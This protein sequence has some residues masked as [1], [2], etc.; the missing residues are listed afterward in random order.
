MNGFLCIFYEF[1]EQLVEDVLLVYIVRAGVHNHR[2][3]SGNG[4][5]TAMVE[6][7]VVGVEGFEGIGVGKEVGLIDGGNA[8][9]KGSKG[10]NVGIGIEGFALDG[11]RKRVVARCW[12]VVQRVEI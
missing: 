11:G 7:A 8:L 1:V 4:T 2:G 5:K 9:C 10:G 6:M 12:G 3:G